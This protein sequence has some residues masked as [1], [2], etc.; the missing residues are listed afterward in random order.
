MSDATGPT[1]DPLLIEVVDFVMPLLPPYETSLYLLLLRLSYLTTG[2]LTICIGKRSIAQALGKGTR[3]SSGN[4]QHITEKLQ[5][6]AQSGFIEIGD[7]DRRGTEYL[8]RRPHEV[9]IV[10]EQMAAARIADAGP[11]DYYTDPALRQEL[12]VRDQWK[13]RYCGVTVTDQ[14]ATL[15]HMTPVSKG[16][17]SEAE[18]LAT[19]CM[20]CNSI[21]SGRTYEEAAPQILARLAALRSQESS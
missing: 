8:V 3:S 16:G 4:Y 7:T 18:N 17:G 2:E 21:K 13:C 11:I 20:M 12:F 15:D 9:P 5:N 6:L 1:N 14:T 10:M 19:C